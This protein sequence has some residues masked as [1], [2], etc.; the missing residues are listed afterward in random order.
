MKLTLA[1]TCATP[2]SWADVSHKLGSL[3]RLV[4]LKAM[5]TGLGRPGV[6]TLGH[7]GCHVH[8]LLSIHGKLGS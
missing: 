8:H 7:G 6:G 3:G 1:H 5:C 2:R 4:L